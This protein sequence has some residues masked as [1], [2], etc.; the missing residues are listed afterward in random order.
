MFK[1][2]LPV[3]T[4]ILTDEELLPFFNH[5]PGTNLKVQSAEVWIVVN[6]ISDF[7]GMLV[8]LC[9]GVFRLQNCY[10][11]DNRLCP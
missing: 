11:A 4:H 10:K 1:I 8:I 5:L 7:G 2:F 6:N 9:L 3:G